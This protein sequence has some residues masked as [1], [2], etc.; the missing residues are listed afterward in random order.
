[1]SPGSAGPGRPA[2]SLR[3][4][5]LLCFLGALL[6]LELPE[7]PAGPPLEWRSDLE[8]ALAEAAAE[9]RPAILS[10]YAVWCSVCRKLDARSLRAPEVAAELERFVRVRVDASSRDRPTSDLLARFGVH[11]LPALRFVDPD[12]MLLAEPRVLGYAPPERLVEVLREVGVSGEPG[13]DDGQR[14]P[15]PAAVSLPLPGSASVR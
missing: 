3:A 6:Y 8:A 9:R 4:I 7:T 10:F 15:A 5:A 12:G 1:V 14:P 13:R 11:G 2:R